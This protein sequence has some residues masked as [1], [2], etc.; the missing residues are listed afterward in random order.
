MLVS[1]PV[2]VTDTGAEA[3]SGGVRR[4]LA[5]V[6]VIGGLMIVGWLIAAL[7]G[8]TGSAS[9]AADSTAAPWPALA[10]ARQQTAAGSATATADGFPTARGS[11][12]VPGDAEAMAGRGVQGLTSQSEPIFPAPSTADP[13]SGA[14]GF[15]PHSGGTGPFGPGTGDVARSTFDPRLTVRRVPLARVPFPA[16]RTAADEPSFSPD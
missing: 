7:F 5:R 1:S 8:F 6:L 16:V 11:T 2:P 15:V 12:Q 4:A 14:D 13:G 10:E 9:A 3:S